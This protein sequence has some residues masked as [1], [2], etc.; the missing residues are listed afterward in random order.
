MI[1]DPIPTK[2]ELLLLV[3]Q[4]EIFTYYIGPITNKHFI[5]PFRRDKKP[6]CSWHYC[7]G[8]L[9]LRDWAVGDYD[10]FKAVM[11]MKGVSYRDAL[12][13][14]YKD[15]IGSK[16][17]KPDVQQIEEVKKRPPKSQIKVMRCAWNKRNYA[18]WKDYHL[19]VSTLNHFNISPIQAFWINNK[20][21]QPKLGYCYHY[22]NYDYTI[23]Q[24]N[25]DYKWLKNHTHYPGLKQLGYNSNYIVITKSLKDVA[26]LYEHNISSIAVPGE[27][28]II[29]EDLMSHIQ[30]NF[31]YIFT[32]FDNDKTGKRCS[33]NHRN[34]YST[35]PLFMPLHKDFSDYRKNEGIQNTQKLID[36]TIN[37]II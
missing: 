3:S 12:H 31:N 14:I 18:Y 19:S 9:Y 5:S 10:C 15:M 23:L 11:Q 7:N 32:L 8:R 17:P 21:I 13:L 29:D 16:I 26:C 37:S 22:S 2:E 34:L 6:T 30:A 27:T 1:R 28:V 4:E 25:S 33:I 20:M 24:P 36:A 35:I